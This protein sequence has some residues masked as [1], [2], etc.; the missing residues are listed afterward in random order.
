MCGEVGV[1]YFFEVILSYDV[2]W[3]MMFFHKFV[4][5][6]GLFKRRIIYLDIWCILISCK[7]KILQKSNSRTLN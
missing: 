3:H 6:L 2:F 4:S 7:Y 1:A 5:I